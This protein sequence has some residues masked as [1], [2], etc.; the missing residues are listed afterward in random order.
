[1]LRHKLKSKSTLKL[2][3]SQIKID[4]Q[5]KPDSQIKIDCQ[6]KTDHQVNLNFQVKIKCQLTS[7]LKSKST[8]K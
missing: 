6:V 3:V 8:F 5:V 4:C 1:M 2:I 7:T